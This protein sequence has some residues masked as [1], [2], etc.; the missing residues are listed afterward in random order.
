MKYMKITKDDLKKMLGFQTELESLSEMDNV[1]YFFEELE[2][3]EYEREILNALKRIESDTQIVGTEERR[4]IWENGWGE[5][6]EELQVSKDTTSLIPKYFHSG[7]PIR[8][9]GRF[10]KSDISG[11]QERLEMLIKRCLFEQYACDKQYIYEFGCGT[12]YNLAMASKIYADKQYFGY[13]YTS[14]SGKVVQYLHKELN[15]SNLFWGGEF[16][17]THP[18]ET[19]SLRKNN[20]VYTMAALEQIGN[21]SHAFI[22]YLLQQKAECVVH[23]EPIVEL[24]DDNKLLDYLAKRFHMKRHY[25]SGLYPYLKELEKNDRIVIE[26][27]K[28][29]YFG[30]CNHEP[31]TL[32]VWRT[33]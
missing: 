16:D 21:R 8:F 18:N 20:V 26:K 24:Y 29:C 30:D 10:I 33:V 4:F 14:S 11:F 31:Y 22:N 5:N 27:V 1:D 9:Q 19:L 2:Q 3:E 6:L 7:R 15:Y 28:R 13:D 12:G 17:F 25:L 32:I 23:L